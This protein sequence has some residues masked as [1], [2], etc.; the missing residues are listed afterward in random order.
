[1][2]SI[3]P[4]SHWS[5]IWF[6]HV[7]FNDIRKPLF[8]SVLL[9]GIFQLFHWQLVDSEETCNWVIVKS[10]KRGFGQSNGVKELR[11]VIGGNRGPRA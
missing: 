8:Q 4:D 7:R 9:S 2:G 5:V 10:L 11:L 1:M 6:I 3:V